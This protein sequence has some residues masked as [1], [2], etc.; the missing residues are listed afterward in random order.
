MA[1]L[2]HITAAD[3]VK[4]ILR[5]GIAARRLRL[6]A[7]HDRAVWVFPVL[8][9]HTLTHSWAR[10]LKR[11]GA[12]T[13]AAVTIQVPDQELC[14]L[15][16]FN[17]PPQQGTVADAIGAIASLD[18]PRGYEIIIPRRIKPSEIVRARVLQRAFGWRF[19]PNAKGR[20]PPTCDCPMCRDTIKGRRTRE[21]ITARLERERQAK[22]AK[23]RRTFKDLLDP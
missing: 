7:Q 21:R 11:G 14:F 5:N 2:I 9:S 6:D 19:F 12:T 23:P 18:D 8:P 1:R 13:I 17:H 3:N 22:A 15:R 20:L 10:E 16:Y 4:A